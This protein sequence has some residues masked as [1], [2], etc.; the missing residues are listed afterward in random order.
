MNSE[1]YF[2]FDPDRE[3][4]TRPMAEL[5]AELAE[6]TNRPLWNVSSTIE[7]SK[8]NRESYRNRHKAPS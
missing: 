8:T 5:L 2:T 3:I 7:E 1:E 6:R 4:T